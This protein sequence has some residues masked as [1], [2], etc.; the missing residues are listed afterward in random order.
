MKINLTLYGTPYVPCTQRGTPITVGSAQLGDVEAF[1][2]LGS[3]LSKDCTL[4]KEITY[5]IGR[6]AASF[7]S[8]RERVFSN[9]NLRITT[10][11][12]VYTAVCVSTLLYGSEA[13]TVYRRQVRK[14]E[15]FH[16]GCLQ[17]ILGIT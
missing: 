10:K 4:E 13:W 5:R 16:I 2:Y 3:Y 15:S 14:L 8:L 1:R 12:N 17:K 11:V 9:R 6:S 7:G